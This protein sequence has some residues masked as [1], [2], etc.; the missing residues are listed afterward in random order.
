MVWALESQ[1][2]F[3]LASSID[4]ICKSRDLALVT[5]VWESRQAEQLNHHSGPDP[6]LRVGSHL[7]Y[8]QTAGASEGASSA[9]PKHQDLH[10]TE[11]QQNLWGESSWGSSSDSVA[12]ARGLELDQ[13]PIAT[14]ISKWSFWISCETHCDPTQLPQKGFVLFCLFC[15][16]KA[17]KVDGGCGGIGRWMGLKLIWCSGRINKKFLQTLMVSHAYWAL[18][19]QPVVLKVACTP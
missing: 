16:G 18:T 9:E 5:W 13:W 3:L 17:A 10:D 1:S 6:R 19:I 11:Q 14:N 12:K 4:C 8:L 15:V 2:L 7:S